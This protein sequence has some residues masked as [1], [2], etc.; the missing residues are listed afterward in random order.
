MCLRFRKIVLTGLDCASQPATMGW[1]NEYLMTIF[2]GTLLVS[3]YCSGQ[4]FLNP[5]TTTSPQDAVF[6]TDELNLKDMTISLLEYVS[7]IRSEYWSSYSHNLT[8]T[9]PMTEVVLSSETVGVC[10]ALQG[11][12]TGRSICLPY[13][14]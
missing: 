1:L 10:K 8:L 4:C 9:A 14:F 13:L 2:L 6:R 3:H 7:I 12:I 11:K 5:S